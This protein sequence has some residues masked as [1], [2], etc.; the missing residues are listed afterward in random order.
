M[1]RTAL[2]VNPDGKEAGCGLQLILD[3]VIGNCEILAI[4][5]LAV[6]SLFH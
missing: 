4:G 2:R 6:L 1:A 3:S 5:I